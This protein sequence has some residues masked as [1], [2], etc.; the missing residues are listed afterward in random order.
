MLQNAAN[1]RSLAFL[2]QKIAIMYDY[3]TLQVKYTFNEKKKQRN[4]LKKIQ[5]LYNHS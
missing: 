3:K 5:S 4:K 1:Q 2:D